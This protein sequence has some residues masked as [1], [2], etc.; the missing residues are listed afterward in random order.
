MVYVFRRSLKGERDGWM[1][2][3][4]VR[5]GRGNFFLRFLEFL[6]RR[7]GI[8]RKNFSLSISGGVEGGCPGGWPRRECF[9]DQRYS[10][11]KV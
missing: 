7:M 4:G 9:H 8:V 6:S 1:D 5:G 3:G 11:E 10:S 2:K